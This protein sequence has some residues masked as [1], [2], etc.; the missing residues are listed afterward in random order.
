[1]HTKYT[2]PAD[3]RQL[4]ARVANKSF[5]ASGMLDHQ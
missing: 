3:R 4:C 1:M 2:D 5:L